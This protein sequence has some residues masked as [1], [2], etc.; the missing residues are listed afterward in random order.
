MRTVTARTVRLPG[1]GRRSGRVDGAPAPIT[2]GITKRSRVLVSAAMSRKLLTTVVLVVLLA[3]VV[4]V[5]D[6][7][8]RP[9]TAMDD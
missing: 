3:V 6:S 4:R 2:R 5:A 9:L 8:T 7:Y 1:D